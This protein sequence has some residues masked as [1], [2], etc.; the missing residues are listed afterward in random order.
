MRTEKRDGIDAPLLFSECVALLM[1]RINGRF[2][3]ELVISVTSEHW[4]G[5]VWKSR[6]SSAILRLKGVN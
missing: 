1:A 2:Q 6:S 3:K 4:C 5:M